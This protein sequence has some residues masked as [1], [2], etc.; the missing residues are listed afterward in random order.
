LKKSDTIHIGDFVYCRSKYYRD[1][2]QLPER[3]LGLVIE[4]KRNNFKIL[5]SNDK[6][7]WLP[8]EA[9]VRIKPELDYSTFPER[10]Y[11]IIK[12]LHAQEVELISDKGM[13]KLSL[14]I[15]EIDHTTVDDIRRFLGDLFVS[16][17]VIPEGM[18]FMQVEVVFKVTGE[19]F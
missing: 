18:A 16:L 11:Y 9:I 4:N 6:R 3:Q 14:R 17:T 1:Q 2:L 15:D 12:K 13:H 10:L 5:Y 7:A 8:S 19:G